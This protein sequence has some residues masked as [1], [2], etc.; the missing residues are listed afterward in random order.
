MPV[1][2]NFG[3]I[4]SGYNIFRGDPSA[5]G[6]GSDPGFTGRPLFKTDFS[7]CE[8]TADQQHRTPKGV[9]MLGDSGCSI[10]W[11]RK[12]FS[13]AKAYA[14]QASHGMSIGAQVE[15]PVPDA[16]GVSASAGFGLSNSYSSARSDISQ[17]NWKMTHSQA[18]CSV[19]RM[20]LS[21]DPPE[22]SSVFGN[23]IDR[24]NLDEASFHEMFDVYGTHYLTQMKMG[25]KYGHQRFVGECD[26][27]R[28]SEE[29]HSHSFDLNLG[30]K[31]VDEASAGFG[32]HWDSSHATQEEN[33]WHTAFSSQKVVTLGTALQFDD[34]GM[35]DWGARSKVDPMPIRYDMDFICKHPAMQSHQDDCNSA[36]QTYC[37]YLQQSNPNLPCLASEEQDDP[38]CLWDSDCGD[39]TQH[40]CNQG[41]CV[42][43]SSPQVTIKQPA[44]EKGSYH[45]RSL[46]L[47]QA[48]LLA[49]PDGCFIADDQYC[50]DGQAPYPLTWGG[51][52]Y[53][54]RISLPAGL[55]VDFLRLTQSWGT[56]HDQ[57]CSSHAREGTPTSKCGPVEDFDFW[58]YSNRVGGWR[59]YLDPSS[60]QN[61]RHPPTSVGNSSATP[62]SNS[63]VIVV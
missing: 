53:A 26:A 46:T 16:P 47:D 40:Q 51:S 45:C 59:F 20:V 5:P 31:V 6:A 27:K 44:E 4:F 21:T 49:N 12:E 24:M 9:S 23:Y 42:A 50:P 3:Y 25:S 1:Y 38:A 17:N 28:A 8:K 10:S 36:L 14:S 11:D 22:T 52:F 41:E 54:G 30:L 60:E 56:I 62:V 39:A 37:Q 61:C 43:R 15:V 55:C 2:Q 57:R 63:S 19:Y 48:T 32:A 13:S 29:T 18:E 7:G 58:D 33:T 35:D 34:Q